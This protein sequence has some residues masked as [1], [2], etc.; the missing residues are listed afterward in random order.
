[1]EEK[2]LVVRWNQVAGVDGYDIFVSQGKKTLKAGDL[3]KSV[4][5]A[6]KV[7]IRIKKRNGKN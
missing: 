1:M 6:G 7:S 5:G 4:Q 3:V 2:A